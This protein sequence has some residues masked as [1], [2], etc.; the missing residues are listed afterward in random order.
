MA[1]IVARVEPED[2]DAWYTD[3]M[4]AIPV[5]REAGVVSEVMYR[6]RNQSNARVGILEVEDVDRFFSF[7]ASRPE[8]AKYRPTLWVLDEMERT[9]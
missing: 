4:K 9:I 2:L 6:D 5:F 8:A 7:V 1:I 3:H